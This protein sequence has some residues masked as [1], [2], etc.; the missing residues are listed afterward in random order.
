MIKFR[1]FRQT[2]VIGNLRTAEINYKL[3]KVKMKNLLLVLSMFLL[4]SNLFAQD[5][6]DIKEESTKMDAFAS[7]T[8][9]I[10]KYIDYSLP[11]LKLTYGIAET[12]IRKFISGLDIE[13]FYQISKEGKYDAKT[14]S[15]AY[16]DLL[17]VIKAIESLKNESASDK[18]L[19][20]DYLENKFVTDDGFKL[21][22]YVSK[23]KLA[24]YLVLEKYGSGNTIFTNDVSVIESAFNSAKQKIEE[25]K[26]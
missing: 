8:G 26:N 5:A 13:Y 14:A 18:A 12:K 19:N 7:K 9:V 1:V 23:G 17:E 4:T 25:L 11:N 16:E 24:W 3:N 2:D 21:G 10:I 6:K 15:I 22:Y 20:P